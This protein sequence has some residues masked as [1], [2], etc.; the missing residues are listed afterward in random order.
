MENT[1]RQELQKTTQT[2]RVYFIQNTT[3]TFFMI[4]TKVD[5]DGDRDDW[6]IADNQIS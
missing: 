2:I 5:F 3:A 6:Q 4:S 1:E